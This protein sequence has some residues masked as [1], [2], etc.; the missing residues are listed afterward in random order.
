MNLLLH[1]GSPPACQVTDVNP[2]GPA[3]H[4]RLLLTSLTCRVHPRSGSNRAVGGLPDPTPGSPSIHL[5]QTLP[6]PALPPPCPTG[7][8]PHPLSG[9]GK[10]QEGSSH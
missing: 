7:A 6:T 1:G 10:A 5:A 4:R 9:S 2:G 3:C 8:H